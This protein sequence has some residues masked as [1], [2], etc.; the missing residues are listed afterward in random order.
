VEAAALANSFSSASEWEE[1]GGAG[2]N[3]VSRGGRAGMTR[4]SSGRGAER[5]SMGR[6]GI[7]RWTRRRLPQRGGGTGI[8]SGGA[9]ERDARAGGRREAEHDAHVD[10]YNEDL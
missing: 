7:S 10:A 3:G 5:G 8:T 6:A 9:Q 1:E 2:G 4:Q